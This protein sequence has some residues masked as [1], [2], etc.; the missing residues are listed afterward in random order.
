[1]TAAMAMAARP[2]VRALDRPGQVGTVTVALPEYSSEVGVPQGTDGAR[3]AA[4]DREGGACC[5]H[6][7]DY[8]R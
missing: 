7:L 2:M 3:H 6:R 1:M 4:A 8:G 5:I